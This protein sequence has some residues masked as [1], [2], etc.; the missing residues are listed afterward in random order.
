VTRD[1]HVVGDAE[2][3]VVGAPDTAV[4]AVL[5]RDHH[6]RAAETDLDRVFGARH[7][8]G[9]AEAEPLVG[10]LDLLAVADGLLEDPELVADPVALAGK[11]QR[12]HGLEEACGETPEAPVAEPGLRLLIEQIVEVDAEL[13]QDLAV[14]A[15]D[16]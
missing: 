4:A 5:A 6:R 10:P 2:H 3:G 11:A 8:P 16:A 9:V 1:R 12:G 15:L 7:L 14:G 13:P